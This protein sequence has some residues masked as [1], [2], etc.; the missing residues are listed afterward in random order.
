M[1]LIGGRAESKES[2]YGIRLGVQGGY[3]VSGTKTRLYSL[4]QTPIQGESTLSGSSGVGGVTLD[5]GGLC[6][7]YYGLA[8]GM[9]LLN[10]KGQAS[11]KAVYMDLVSEKTK[12]QVQRMFDFSGKLGYLLYDCV[13]PYVK[14]GLSWAHV[15]AYTMSDASVYGSRSSLKSGINA[16]AGIEIAVK[17]NM[18]MGLEYDYRHYSDLSYRIRNIDNQ[19]VR[20]MKIGMSLN[21]AMVFARFKLY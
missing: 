11:T 8:G 10:V 14:C 20:K 9:Y 18:C 7:F 13:L 15:K 4:T 21:T 1:L 6:R 19:A 2:L 12:T 5:V 16:G 3:I 17:G